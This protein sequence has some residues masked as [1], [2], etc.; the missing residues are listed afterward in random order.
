MK[1]SKGNEVNGG[2]TWNGDKKPYGIEHVWS[3]N[4][5]ANETYRLVQ[6][7]NKE[8]SQ[9]QQVRLYYSAVPN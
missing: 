3:F 7:A 6:T 5:V 2:Q 8:Y 1:D 9:Y 4:G